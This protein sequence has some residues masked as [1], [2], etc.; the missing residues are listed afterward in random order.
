MSGELGRLYIALAGDTK[1]WDRAIAKVQRDIRSTIGRTAMDASM[2]LTKAFGALA[3]GMGA[4]GVAAVKMAANFEQQ[5]IAFTTLLKDAGKAEQFLKRLQAFADSTPFEFDELVGASR[6]ILAFGFNAE[7]V[8]DILTRIGDASAGL[9]IGAEGIDRIVRGLGQMRAKGKVS[10]EEMN[11]LAENGINGW[12][13]LADAAGKSTAEVMKAAEKGAISG[14]TAIKVILEGM[15]KQFGGMM[16][17]Q[18]NTML[19]IFSTIKDKV[20]GAMK[21]IGA[22]ITDSLGIR[23]AL[24]SLRDAIG[25]ISDAVQKSGAINSLNLFFANM[26]EGNRAAIYAVSAA[27][28]AALLPAIISLGAASLKLVPLAMTLGAIAVAVYFAVRAWQEWDAIMLRVG[29]AW[30]YIRG[31]FTTGA[32]V[33]SEVVQTALSA[34]TAAFLRCMAGLAYYAGEGM[35]A[36]ADSLRNSLP[37]GFGWIATA[38]DSVAATTSGLYDKLKGK[39]EEYA[40]AAATHSQKIGDAALSAG[41]KIK[42]DMDER[43]RKYDVEKKALEENARVTK[44]WLENSKDVNAMFDRIKAN[45]KA[46]FNEL[47]SSSTTAWNMAI[48]GAQR[49]IV[50][51]SE[52]AANAN[53]VAA[54]VA[55]IAKAW[56]M[57]TGGVEGGGAPVPLDIPKPK[58]GGGGGGKSQADK[59]KEAAELYRSTLDDL[60]GLQNSPLYQPDG[61]ATFFKNLGQE[62]QATR[63]RWFQTFDQL[64][65]KWAETSAAGRA[66]MVRAMNEAGIAYQLAENGKLSFA[67]A[68]A[69]AELEIERQKQ[70]AAME[71]V[72]TGQML[73]DEM[74]RALNERNLTEYMQLLS[75]KNAAF[76]SQLNAERA[77]ADQYMQFQLEANRSALSYMTEASQ[78]IYSGLTDAIVGVVTGTKKASEAFRDLGKQIVA[79]VVKWMVQRM[80]AATMAK[81]LERAAAASSSATAATVASAWTNAASMVSLATMGANAGPAM[82]G[83]GATVA[84]TKALAAIPMAKGGIV[85][86]PTFALLGEGRDREAVL[87]LNDRVLSKIG[88]GGEVR[89]NIYNNTGAQVSARQERS[90]DGQATLVSVFLDAFDRDV[91]GLRTAVTSRR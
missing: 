66:S 71:Y 46:T 86:S 67:Q 3:L 78:V 72:R 36:V 47:S 79:M 21:S 63:D 77:A 8:F 15:N 22:E 49:F 74:R 58:S 45:I 11:Q 59:M 9:G 73:E 41:A 54:T 14:N 25:G 20:A 5:R 81:G 75:N 50:K 1:E 90:V 33:I 52:V 62:A 16:S 10:A 42:R 44:W 2:K 12:K 82:A 68:R 4:V 30:D 24:A 26:N 64:E 28:V 43:K 57:V 87:P 40:R 83:I 37:T 88:G 29:Y 39:S 69:S 19:G 17:Q 56:S 18:A 89:V 65:A 61:A 38:I 13:Y 70:A 84:S 34:I 48:N 53:I 91:G 7:E 32:A 60:R 51:L 27:L 85:D 23:D 76:L 55:G 31:I 80:L 6:K 35:K